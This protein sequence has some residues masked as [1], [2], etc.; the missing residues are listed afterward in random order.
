VRGAAGEI[1]RIKTFGNGLFKAFPGVLFFTLHLHPLRIAV[2]CPGFYWI[3]QLP[4][5]AA[6]SMFILQ[7]IIFQYFLDC[8]LAREQDNRNTGAR[9]DRTAGKI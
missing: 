9:M 2:N 3:M 1:R 5:A 6:W 4:N 7:F 8:K